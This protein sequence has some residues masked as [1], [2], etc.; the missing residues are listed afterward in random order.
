M[1]IVPKGF[2]GVDEESCPFPRG[3]RVGR[4]T[5]EFQRAQR[6]TRLKNWSLA[7]TTTAVGIATLILVKNHHDK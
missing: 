4:E 1:C 6:R 5:D 7:I 3:K 2:A